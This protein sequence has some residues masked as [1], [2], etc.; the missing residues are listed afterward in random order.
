MVVLAEAL[1]AR[2]ANPHTELLF[3]PVRT[4]YHLCHD[5]SHLEQSTCHQYLANH[6]GE[7]CYIESSV[8]ISAGRFGTPQCLP[9]GQP[10]QTEAWVITEPLCN[11]HPCYH[12]LL[13]HEL[14]GWWQRWPGKKADWCP[15]VRSSCPLDY[16]NPLLLRSVFGQ[17]SHGTQY[18]HIFHPFREV[19]MP[20]LPQISLSPIFQSCFFQVP[21]PNNPV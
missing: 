2:K 4:K 9:P 7:W 14:I 3:I 19:Y 11:L 10:W 21:E 18:F 17:H 13:V 12:D 16:Q 1:H 8:L 5:G 20:C 6:P 15:Q